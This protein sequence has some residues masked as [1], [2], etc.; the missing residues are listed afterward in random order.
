MISN[1]LILLGIALFPYAALMIIISFPF[2]L[3]EKE[4]P[5]VSYFHR[6][7]LHVTSI[8]LSLH[9]Y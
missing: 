1:I 2:A 3:F 7:S 8:H 5:F 9:F 4:E 6:F